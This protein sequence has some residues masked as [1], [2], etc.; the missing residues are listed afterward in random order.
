MYHS[1]H[2]T[3]LKKTEA[4]FFW[5]RPSHPGLM[6][7]LTSRRSSHPRV[8]TPPPP[9]RTPTQHEHQSRKPETNG[10][11]EES[12]M[13][14][15]PEGERQGKKSLRFQP[16]ERIGLFTRKEKERKRKLVCCSSLGLSSP[17]S[18][19]HPSPYTS[20]SSP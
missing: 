17:S 7:A 4:P 8:A 5:L 11:E 18:E 10:S 1:S 15:A 3:E 14:Q 9:P 13:R 2:Q 6:P 19:L 20:F 12:D 16:T